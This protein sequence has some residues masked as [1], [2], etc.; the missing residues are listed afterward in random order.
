MDKSDHFRFVSLLALELDN[1]DISLPS[2]P[3]VV[4]K[5]RNMLERDDCDF[6]KVSQAVSVDPVLVSKLFVYANSAYYNRANV[7]IESLESVIGRLGFEVVRNTAMSLAMKQLY[8]SDKHDKTA[9]Q[10]RKIWAN[11]MKMS[12]MAFAIAQKQPALNQE[13]AFLCG[14]MHEV[15]KLYIL[16]KAED[17]PELIGDAA[18]LQLVFDEWNPQI[19]KSIIESWGF[20]ED[21]V[22]TADPVSYVQHDTSA[23]ADLVDVI[24][25][26]RLLLDGNEA[27][28][29]QVFDEDESCQRL[30][31]GKDVAP[32]LMSA[33][34][35]K[36]QSMQ[37]SLT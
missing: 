14:L 27:K 6:D 12:S 23:P 7:K 32:A 17:F 4:I 11:G 22:H 35:E 15:G 1:G 9:G 33:Y 18:S 20:S 13:T 30:G 19:S 2:L 37:Q 21:V 10:Q 31:V 8:D 5:I 36:L 29:E 16:T 24:V 26:S 34:R 25:V 28:L 3:D